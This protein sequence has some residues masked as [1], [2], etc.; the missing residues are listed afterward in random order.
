MYELLSQIKETETEFA[1]QTVEGHELSI[2]NRLLLEHQGGEEG[3]Y[4]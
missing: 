4:G 1:A 3:I 2:N